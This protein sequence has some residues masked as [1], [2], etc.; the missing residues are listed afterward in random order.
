MSGQVQ[1]LLFL[2]I[3]GKND[4]DINLNLNLH[5]REDVESNLWKVLKAF[6]IT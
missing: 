3:Y 5:C 2:Q 6:S 1:T 4:E